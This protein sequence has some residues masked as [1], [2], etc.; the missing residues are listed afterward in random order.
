[1]NVKALLTTA[2]VVIGVWIRL[3]EA[4]AAMQPPVATP[5]A[6]ASV[7]DVPQRAAPAGLGAVALPV[8]ESGIAALFERLPATIAGEERAEDAVGGDDD[9]LVV[10]YGAD[11]AGLGPPLAIQAIDLTSGDFWPADW[12]A[13]LVVLALASGADWSVDG[14]GRDGDLVWIR[15][16]T[17]ASIADDRTSTPAVSRTLYS[18]NWGRIGEPWLFGAAADTPERLDAVIAAFVN[19]A[20]A[21]SGTPEATPS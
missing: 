6:M 10:A 3:P 16:Q 11:F 2:L 15:W 21:D 9:R 4:Q 12:T 18:V 17:V 1:M 8:D 7:E 13:E 5:G 19:A 20:A 14:V